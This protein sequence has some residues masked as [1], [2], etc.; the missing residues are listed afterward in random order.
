M[1]SRPG[2]S[3]RPANRLP[4]ITALPPAAR[5]FTISPEYLIP[6]S[7]ITGILYFAASSAQSSTAENCGI[8][9]P[10]MILVVQIEPGPIPIFTASAP[11]SIMR[12]VASAVTVF[13]P[14]TSILYF[15]L[16]SLI[17]TADSLVSPVA[18]SMTTKST[19]LSIKRG[20]RWS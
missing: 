10:E 11:A 15:F 18:V 6:P 5:A 1:I 12:F 19:L 3:L 13:P 14:I 2:A 8:P 4:I 7:A 9:Q 20:I 17:A 16:I